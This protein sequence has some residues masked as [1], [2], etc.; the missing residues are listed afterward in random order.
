[1]FAKT[2]AKHVKKTLL[3][4][5]T[6][7]GLTGLLVSASLVG[8]VTASQGA[9]PVV[10]D[11]Y[12]GQHSMQFG[13]PGSNG[14]LQPFDFN[15]ENIAVFDV[16]INDFSLQWYEE[17]SYGD[18]SVI[19]FADSSEVFP[20]DIAMVYDN[21]PEQTPMGV[22]LTIPLAETKLAVDTWPITL[23]RFFVPE[24]DV[25][26]SITSFRDFNPCIGSLADADTQ[27]VDDAFDETFIEL[28]ESE[29]GFGTIKVL[30]EGS[31]STLQADTVSKTIV[32]KSVQDGVT[33]FSYDTE[34]F[35]DVEGA[36]GS[37]V[38]VNVNVKF[39]GNTIT[40][41]V[42]AFEPGTATPA[43][44]TFYIEGNLGS[45]GRTQTFTS[46]GLT[47]NT[48]GFFGDPALVLATDSATTTRITE[49]TVRFSAEDV[50]SGFVEVSVI[51]FDRC[52]TQAEIVAA[53]DDFTDNYQDN[54]NTD[55]PD[56]VGA[57]C[58]RE[59]Q[60][61]TA[62]LERSPGD[63]D[64][65]GIPLCFDT[66]FDLAE[67]SDPE[68]LLEQEVLEDQDN[69]GNNFVLGDS[70]DY[71]NVAIG[72]DTVLNAIVTVSTTY[73]LEDNEVDEVDDYG[74]RNNGWIN[75]GLDFEPGEEDRYA[76][77]TIQFYVSGDVSRTAVRVSNLSLDA[78]DVDNHQ[79]FGASGVSTYSLAEETI[80]TATATGEQLRVSEN[81]G[82][83]SSSGEESRVSVNFKPANS[84]VIRM[85][86]T[87]G[88]SDYS[89]ASFDLDFTG[90]TE[91]ESP[92]VEEEF[93]PG[94]VSSGGAT[95]L[96]TP[97]YSFVAKKAVYSFIPESPKLLKAQQAQ[98]KAFLKKNPNISKISCTGYTAG[99]VKKSH[100]A[101]AKKRASN[102]CAYIE[103]IRPGVDT[104]VAAKTLGL[105]F[106]PLSRKVVIRGSSV[107]P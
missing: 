20:S 43:D 41:N 69:I 22:R 98:I 102:V 16:P 9:P 99:P 59:C 83:G 12:C 82:E 100:M 68:V 27:N 34:R 26:N 80:L 6:S 106:S 31:Y 81:S 10:T 96:P 93:K 87:E 53:I 29:E 18:S 91:W 75:T 56:L 38:D 36:S 64:L 37:L 76:E 33:A 51:G 62:T 55:I 24:F 63:F 5:S 17:R 47:Y 103:R 84:F 90:L 2:K 65:A 4:K 15:G 7:I 78:Y 88:N 35:S 23:D 3:Q 11:I 57:A 105:P 48:D 39:A 42:Q 19:T 44:L 74:F 46:N 50:T 70:I 94:R 30:E 1:M 97:T 40:W 25:I 89:G 8:L 58:N 60:P 77:Y 71:Q 101:L 73:L 72:G 49:D 54:K 66:G 85:G 79:F 86:M 67:G 45:D 95:F 13:D 61:S 52:A 107:N 14:D 28:S 92:P 21:D 32:R 104:T